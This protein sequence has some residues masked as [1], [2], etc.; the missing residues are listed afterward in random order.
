MQD[1]LRVGRV[2]SRSGVGSPPLGGALMVA[3]TT[4]AAQYPPLQRPVAERTTRACISMSGA[5]MRVCSA[6]QNPNPNP[7]P[8]PSPGPSPSPDP[9]PDP[10]SNPSPNS[11]PA[12]VCVCVHLSSPMPSAPQ[13]GE[14]PSH[15]HA[16]VRIRSA[17]WLTLARLVT[18]KRSIITEIELPQPALHAI[19]AATVMAIGNEPRAPMPRVRTQDTAW[20]SFWTISSLFPG[21]SLR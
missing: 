17:I 15:S 19:A 8:S 18:P 10:E 14:P 1:V 21:P 2:H 12:C 13:S 16:C 6:V 20:Q 9:N 4:T 3:K 7:C 11:K 5:C